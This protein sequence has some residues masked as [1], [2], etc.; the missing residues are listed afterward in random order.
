MKGDKEIVLYCGSEV[1]LS[2][3]ADLSRFYQRLEKAVAVGKEYHNEKGI[4][5]KRNIDSF[6]KRYDEHKGLI[7]RREKVKLAF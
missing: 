7:E 2:G 4:A 3:E 5:L 6:V 1:S